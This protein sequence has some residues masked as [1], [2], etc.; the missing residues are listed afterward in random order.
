MSKVSDDVKRAIVKACMANGIEDMNE[1]L[2]IT[3]Q[4]INTMGSMTVAAHKAWNTMRSPAHIH[5]KHCK[6]KKR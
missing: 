3:A 4:A 6:H 2:G 5:C 1:I